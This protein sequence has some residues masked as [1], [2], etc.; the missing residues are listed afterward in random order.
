[1]VHVKN[2]ESFIKMM[3]VMCMSQILCFALQVSNEPHEGVQNMHEES[4]VV[5]NDQ[6]DG[7]G[8]GM[9]IEGMHEDLET[10]KRH[11]ESQENPTLTSSTIHQMVESHKHKFD[12]FFD[13]TI[14]FEVSH[15][16]VCGEDDN[17]EVDAKCGYHDEFEIHEHNDCL[18]LENVMH[19]HKEI[20]QPYELD[21]VDNLNEFNVF[22]DEDDKNEPNVPVGFYTKTLARVHTHWPVAHHPRSGPWLNTRLLLSP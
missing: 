10:H 8:D 19:E 13:E 1:M 20:N 18:F 4:D 16:D 22:L 12:A 3:D 6:G 17:I 21:V 9:E 11:I 14:N 15:E 7:L 5:N 2:E